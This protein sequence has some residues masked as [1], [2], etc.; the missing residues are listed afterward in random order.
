MLPTYQSL[1]DDL[2]QRKLGYA[3]WKNLAEVEDALAGK[4][5]LDL[6]VRVET[7]GLFLERLIANGFVRAHSRYTY[8][9]VE[10]HF[11]W[12]ETAGRFC[13]LHV[14][15]RLVTG[16]SHLKQFCL[17]IESYLDA[18][19]P[20]INTDHGLLEC[21]PQV[22]QRLHLFR[23]RIKLSSLPGV[24]LYLRERRGYVAETQALDARVTTAQGSYEDLDGWLATVQPAS[25]GM[26]VEA[27][28]GLGHRVELS[29][30]SRFTPLGGWARRYWH[31]VRRPCNKLLRRKKRLDHGMIV[32]VTGLDGSGKSTTVEL[33]QAWLG[34][35]FDVVPV[36]YGHGRLTLWS[37]PVRL[38]LQ[39]RHA[40]SMSRN[41]RD[42]D[43]TAQDAPSAR[44]FVAHVRY[45]AL[46]IER[47]AVVA[48]AVRA[49]SRGC[50]VVSDRW[51]S[52]NKGKMDSP[53][54]DPESVHGLKRW[55]ARLE[56]RCY[57]VSP[58]PDLILRMQVSPQVAVQRNRERDKADKETDEQ[59]IERFRVN[60]AVRYRC[61]NQHIVDNE[62]SLQTVQA[63]VRERVW[64][65]LILR[66]GPWRGHS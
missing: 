14:Y 9:D 5:D 47:K 60:G 15:F 3:L 59:I 19:P 52:L 29:H 27:A 46:A 24:A 64:K 61:I 54:L 8:P 18:F 51:F 6:Y 4:G 2:H 25:G 30:L 35:E 50:I 36:H 48:D 12:D 63:D 26:L 42:A 7:A 21:H 28:R 55:M 40:L 41:A 11:A 32:A 1:F 38:A 17:P 58:D 57:A 31:L 10:H 53:R 23:R 39:L 65:T 33:L 22:L 37:A 13:H 34:R 66:Q 44:S 49:A 62:R 16:E 43:R 56:N 20:T 45:L